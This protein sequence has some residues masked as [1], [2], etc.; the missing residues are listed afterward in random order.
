MVR[1][2]RR[3]REG[4]DEEERSKKRGETMKE[5]EECE[6]EERVGMGIGKAGRGGIVNE[7]EGEEY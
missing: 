2:R 3:G 1:R 4:W 7:E 5:K 6:G